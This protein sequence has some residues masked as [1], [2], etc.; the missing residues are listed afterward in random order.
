MLH[1]DGN[2]AEPQVA[3]DCELWTPHVVPGGWIIFD[4]YEWA[5]GDGPRRVADAF[6]AAR[7]SDIAAVFQAGPALF[8]QLKRCARD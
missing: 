8:V 2:H 5:F 1:I 4:D 6:V 3:S 7:S